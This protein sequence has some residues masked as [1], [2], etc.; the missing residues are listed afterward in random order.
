LET[1]LA[2]DQARRR[3]DEADQLIGLMMIL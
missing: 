3:R 2:A 1:T